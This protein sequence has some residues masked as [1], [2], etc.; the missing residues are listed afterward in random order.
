M[1]PVPL[2]RHVRRLDFHLVVEAHG[3]EV[4]GGV[5]ARAG[6]AHHVGLLLRSLDEIV[7]RFERAVG[8]DDQGV[9]RVVEE[10][11]RRDVGRL[12]ADVALERLQHDVAAG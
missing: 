7:D 3:S 1:S 12:V 4:I 10:V 8:G 5:G 9:R 11:D 2:E 6:D